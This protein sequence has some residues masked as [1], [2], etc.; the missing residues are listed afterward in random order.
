MSFKIDMTLT[1][2]A[3]LRKALQG[4]SERG[5]NKA[6]ADALNSTAFYGRIKVVQALQSSLDRPTKYTLSGAGVVKADENDN[7]A[8]A[9]VGFDIDKRQDI[10]G[11]T[12]AF[13]QTSPGATTRSQYLTQLEQGTRRSKRFEVA[14]R[15]VGALPEGWTVVPGRRAKIDAYGNQ[16]A[17]EIK[18][19]LSYFRAAELVSGSTQNINENKRR[20]M[21]KATTKR[22]G[23]QYFVIKPGQTKSGNRA[24]NLK[25]PG[26]YRS[27]LGGLG[28]RIEPVMIF[29]QRSNY[30]RY[31]DLTEILNRAARDKL[32]KNLQFNIKRVFN[33]ER[34][35]IS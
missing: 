32:A 16:S 14:L 30:R 8:A 19:I 20:R 3:Q 25:Q 27:T 10:R 11:N 1:G 26:I 4:I 31:F 21:A 24:N 6:V 22:Y 33:E 9:Y 28:K 23:V 18:Q 13:I 17:G 5:M 15:A 12:I 35:R 2:A 29:V 7:D 34:G